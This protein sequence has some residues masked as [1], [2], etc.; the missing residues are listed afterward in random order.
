MGIVNASPESFSDGAA[1][2]G[3]DEQVQRALALRDAGAGIVVTANS[4]IHSL[5]AVPVASAMLRALRQV[6][7][8]ATRTLG[9]VMRAVRREMLAEGNPM[10][11]CLSVFGDADWKLAIHAEGN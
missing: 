7:P 11:L 9:E 6:P 8:A 1:V 3:L 2:G 4:T 5:H 10:V